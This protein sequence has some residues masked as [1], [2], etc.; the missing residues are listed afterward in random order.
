MAFRGDIGIAKIDYARITAAAL[1]Y[2][3]AGQGD[4]VG[5]SIYDDKVRQFIPSRYRPIPSARGARGAFEDADVWSDGRSAVV[6]A[7]DRHAR[8]PRPADPRV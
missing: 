2:L 6:E 7:I 1:A 5:V 4:G 3:V 8:T